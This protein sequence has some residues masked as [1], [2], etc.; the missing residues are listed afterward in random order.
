VSRAL[1]LVVLEEDCDISRIERVFAGTSSATLYWLCRLNDDSISTF[2]VSR[3]VVGR[4]PCG[5]G[6]SDL[7]CR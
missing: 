4:G 5:S 3:G 2:L 6:G 1:E 7:S